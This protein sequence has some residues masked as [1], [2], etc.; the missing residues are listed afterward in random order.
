[1]PIDSERS[2]SLRVVPDAA[3]HSRF[4][5]RPVQLDV[6]LPPGYNPAAAAP[7][8]VLYLNDGQDLRRLRLPAILRHLY[9]ER[10][11]QPFVLVAIHAHQ[12]IQEYGTAAQPDYLNRGSRAGLYTEFMVHEL[13]P[14]VQQHYHVTA[15]A[16]QT[17]VA[18]CSLGGLTAFDF[19]WH[20]P[21]TA[22]RAG[23][24]S[25]S[26]WWRQRA[27]NDGYTDA[28][29]I[30]HRLVRA[31]AA[32]PDQQFWLQTGTLDETND[33]NHNGIIDSI[34]DTLDLMAVLVRQGLPDSCIRY[35][36]VAGGRHNQHTWGHLLP[37]FL[38]WAFGVPGATA[39]RAVLQADTSQLTSPWNSRQR[40]HRR[41]HCGNTHFSQYLAASVLP[42]S[43]MSASPR[44]AAGQYNAY[45][46]TY[47]SLVPDGAN[48]LFQLQQQ[49]QELHRL[50]GHLTNE[51]ALF[52][53]APGKWT[54]K[55]SLVHIIDTERIFAYRAL[56][57]ARGDQQPLAGFEQNDYVPTSGANDRTLES[58]LQE[59]DT[60]RAAT[61]S[62][63]ESFQPAAYDRMG[64]AS[65][66]PVSVRALAFILPGHEAHHLHILRERYLPNLP[67]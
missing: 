40:L 54:I 43:F 29:R 6:V 32:H 27:I 28:D 15:A 31:R 19:V 21:E 42:A 36:E 24:F 64:T 9:R 52:A 47:I 39:P 56:R 11:L 60:V 16:A 55:E 51:Q 23:A 66:F 17:V 2:R 53:Y 67:A 22:T 62:L 14:Y 65:G 59:Y 34:E 1:M 61:L 63:Y 38:Y 35:V 10:Q 5:G 30:M 20:H 25:G 41:R 26:F 12:R 8:P 48:P 46:D 45:Y 57:I 44:P 4:L 37:D 7:Y 50:V 33:R 58:I 49:P 18:G 3:L 13:L